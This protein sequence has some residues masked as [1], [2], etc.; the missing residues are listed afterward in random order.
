MGWRQFLVFD[1]GLLVGLVIHGLAELVSIF[2]LT[3]IFTDFY[4]SLSWKAWV[5]IHNMTL[6]SSEA[7]GVFLAWRYIQSHPFQPPPKRVNLV[8]PEQD[9]GRRHV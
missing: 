1:I 2:A 3:T 5:F 6:V 7:V 4:L 9:Q 8:A